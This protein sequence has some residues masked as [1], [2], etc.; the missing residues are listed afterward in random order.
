VEA[1]PVADGTRG[2]LTHLDEKL[3]GRNGHYLREFGH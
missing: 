3:G 2:M 1:D